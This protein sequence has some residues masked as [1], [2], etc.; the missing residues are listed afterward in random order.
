MNRRDFII[1]S[2]T[3]IGASALSMPEMVGATDTS[4]AELAKHF[5]YD[6]HF[7]RLMPGEPARPGWLAT[8]TGKLQDEEQ[9]EWE[10]GEYVEYEVDLVMENLEGAMH[11][12]YIEIAHRE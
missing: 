9:A 2:A 6:I 4:Y 7:V 5:I 11:R 10:A 3:L 1:R 12:R 8:V